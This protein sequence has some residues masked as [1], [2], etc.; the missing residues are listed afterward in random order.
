MK[1][2]PQAIV[3]IRQM[4]GLSQAELARRVGTTPSYLC[5]LEKGDCPGTVQVLRNVAAELHVHIN[6]I[7]LDDGVFRP[8]RPARSKT[9]P[10][11]EHV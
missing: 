9:A 11:P 6:T 1:A 5:R 8:T 10:T 4:A 7:T 2:N 3:D